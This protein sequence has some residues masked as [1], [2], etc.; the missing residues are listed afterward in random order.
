MAFAMDAPDLVPGLVSRGYQAQNTALQVLGTG[1]ALVCFNN[2]GN[3][4]PVTEVLYGSI[5]EVNGLLFHADAADEAIT[6]QDGGPPPVYNNAANFIYAS[7]A[8][9]SDGVSSCGFYRS[10][11]VPAYNSRK[12]G[13]YSQNG[14]GPDRCIGAFLIWDY[15][16]Y[17][18]Q[19]YNSR[20]F[21]NRLF[22]PILYS[23]LMEYR[24]KDGRENF[25]D[26]VISAPKTPA[27]EENFE[28]TG[29]YATT[30]RVKPGVYC[31]VCAAGSGGGAGAGGLGKG[32]VEHREPWGESGSD[33]PGAP[34]EDG[35]AGGLAAEI[36]YVPEPAQFTCVI[37]GRAGRGG[38]GGRSADAG[39]QSPDP[40]PGGEPGRGGKGAIVAVVSGE[41][42]IAA[43]GGK[44]GNGGKGGK[45]GS[46]W[47]WT[48]WPFKIWSTTHTPEY[49][50]PG[51]KNSIT[52]LRAI[53]DI[54]SIYQVSPDRYLYGFSEDYPSGGNLLNVAIPDKEHGG[55]DPVP[56]GVGGKASGANGMNGF[57]GYI[58]F[59]KL[60]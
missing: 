28:D 40:N 22:H 25:P 43:F 24:C 12:G 56:G 23:V 47:R 33:G 49:G 39:N 27:A 17:N 4:D 29:F 2:M 59:Y 16:Y 34:G 32:N 42:A 11:S 37:K 53:T 55:L 1:L 5:V 44:G 51:E 57:D 50:K 36:I 10:N 20:F 35:G 46:S 14:K 15:R 54:V 58:K 8:M 13:F 45:G 26:H 21:Y 18:V 19:A 52:K 48:M 41:Y 6:A 60:D 7:P 3:G 30:I 31:V 38:A 9:S